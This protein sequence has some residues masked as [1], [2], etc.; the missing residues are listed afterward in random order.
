MHT[1]TLL[2]AGIITAFVFIAKES[3]PDRENS[4][5]P[6]GS[7]P[8]EIHPCPPL[9]S[10]VFFPT[11]LSEISNAMI[12]CIA[13]MPGIRTLVLAH[14]LN[15]QENSVCEEATRRIQLQQEMVR[16]SGID[17]VIRVIDSGDISIHEAILATA[18]AEN[19]SLIVVGARKGL[20]SG[21]LLG[22]GAGRVL[23]NSRTHIL[24]MRFDSPGLLHRKIPY[25]PER[26]LC[27][28]IIFPTDF[29][30]PAREALEVLKQSGG[31]SE[32]VL[33]HVIRPLETDG[34]A[35]KRTLCVVNERLRRWQDEL[36]EAGIPA[37]T[38]IRYGKPCDEICQAAVEENASM[39]V[40]SRYGW[41]DYIRQIPLGTTTASVAK[42]AKR[43]VLVV[44][45]EIHVT[46]HAREL[47]KDEFFFAEK[48]WLDYHQTKSDP[49]N[50]RIFGVF[51]EDTPVSVAR[52]KRHTDGFEV[53]GVFTWD[54]FR[55]RG[56]ARKAMEALIA[57]CK[58]ET[59]YMHATLP[60]VTLYS[61]LGFTPI[62]EKELPPTIRA[63]YA[64]AMGEMKGANVCPMK[65][66]PQ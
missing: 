20:L 63:R 54:E 8:S 49:D 10:K 5:H 29:S 44:F 23:T 61:S 1:L 17:T 15:D 50:D 66:A 37:T 16:R 2:M 60:L 34:K 52:C 41:M 19:A 24:I 9:F 32:V 36:G 11:D 4:G 7:Y 30:K 40:M 25:N 38:L 53:D 58:Q 14:F 55:G 27:S 65:R 3:D 56:Y 26:T 13:R 31:V 64:W 39:I 47:Q 12:A 33:L 28:K 42:T 22:P 57:G 45:S 35:Q 21:S 46:V 43:P 48:I 62:P 51:V 6:S 18:D 59:L